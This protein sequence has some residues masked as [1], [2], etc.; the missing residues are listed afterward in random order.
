MTTHDEPPAITSTLTY[1][2]PHTDQLTTWLAD[3]PHH[4]DDGDLVLHTPDG[5]IHPRPGSLLVRWT[6]GIVTSASPRIAERVYGPHGITG[7]LHTT[8]AAVERVRERC[9]AVR[10]RVGP[11][12]MINASQILGLLSPT[13]PDG[14]YEAPAPAALDEPKDQS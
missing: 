5:H 11:G 3:T 8:E 13:W 7:R 4:Y 6:D 1:T 10:D 14:N 2:R 9:Q 12:G